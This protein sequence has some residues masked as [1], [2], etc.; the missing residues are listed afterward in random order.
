MLNGGNPS[1]RFW[2]TK[3]RK[4]T[5]VYFSTTAATRLDLGPWDDV[6]DRTEAD[7]EYA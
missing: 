5:L 1:V 4:Q 7:A 6:G 2:T 3:R